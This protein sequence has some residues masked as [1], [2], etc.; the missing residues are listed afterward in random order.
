MV[1]HTGNLKATIKAIEVVDECLGKIVK[2]C[3][4]KNYTSHSY[5]RSWKC[6]SNV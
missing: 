6:R 5:F 1:G 2:K 4:E 3:I